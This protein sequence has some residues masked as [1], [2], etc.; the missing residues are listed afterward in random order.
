MERNA[1]SAWMGQRRRQPSDRLVTSE[2][3]GRVPHE[4]DARASIGGGSEGGG[5]FAS[6]FSQTCTPP[7][8]VLILIQPFRSKTGTYMETFT[9]PQRT[10]CLSAFCNI[11]S[12][13]ESPS[14]NQN[15]VSI[16]PM[17]LARS[18]GRVRAVW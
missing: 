4:N 10:P 6:G 16:C 2:R 13:F 9:N 5:S 1:F 3:I 8:S 17:L 18:S 15:A 11:G 7:F 14:G 12:N